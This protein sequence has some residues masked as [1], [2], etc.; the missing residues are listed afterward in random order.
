MLMSE[1]SMH[2]FLTPISCEDLLVTADPQ[3]LT[4][5]VLIQ[6]LRSWFLITFIKGAGEYHTII[7]AHKV[8]KWYGNRTF[9]RDLVILE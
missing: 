2:S 6:K 4:I 7:N 5:A 3:G 8:G 1:M 9:F